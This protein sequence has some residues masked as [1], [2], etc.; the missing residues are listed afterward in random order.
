MMKHKLGS[1]DKRRLKQNAH[2][3]RKAV[4]LAL[5]TKQISYTDSC[6]LRNEITVMYD[7]LVHSKA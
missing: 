6:I 7:K 1:R 4:Q 2:R 5:H 3:M